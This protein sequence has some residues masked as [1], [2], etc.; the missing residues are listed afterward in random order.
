MEEEINHKL[1]RMGTN[2]RD[3]IYKD[4]SY[5]VVGL[6]MRVHSELGGGFLDKVYE[7]ALLNT[8]GSLC[9]DLRNNVT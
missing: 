3:I 8:R 5:R 2:E 7:N 9:S 1:T 4:L 6:A